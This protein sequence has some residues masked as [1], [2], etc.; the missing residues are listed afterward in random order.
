MVWIPRTSTSMLVIV[1]SAL[2]L[3]SHAINASPAPLK[4][5]TEADTLVQ[6]LYAKTSSTQILKEIPYKEFWQWHQVQGVYKSEVRLNFHGGLAFR[7]FRETFNV[8][9]NNMFATAWVTSNLLEAYKYGEGPKPTETQI[10]LAL[11]I[12]NINQTRKLYANGN[13][14]PFN[15]NNVDM[16][17]GADVVIG[18]T[19]GVLSGLISS[20][21]LDDPDVAQIYL[22]T[23]SLLAYEI[24]NNLTSRPDLVLTYYPS[25][26]EFYWFVAKTVS[27]METALKKGPLPSE[28]MKKVY[29]I[30]KDACLGAMTKDILAKAQYEEKGKNYF[31]DFLGNADK[32]VFGKPL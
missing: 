26:N 28:V 7:E 6:K 16:T 25:I 30:L 18:L 13:P 27:A 31:D 20:Q 32:D 5:E 8:F 23:S 24:A 14:M 4:F 22:N 9:D 10:N 17:V 15:V 29:A 12:E 1:S 3:I 21:V 11:Q 19:Y 2:L